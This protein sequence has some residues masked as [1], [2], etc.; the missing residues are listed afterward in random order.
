MTARIYGNALRALCRS[1]NWLAPAAAAWRFYA[2][3]FSCTQANAGLA[4][5][6]F[7]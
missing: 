1:A 7:F 4:G 5:D 2:D 6:F 3:S